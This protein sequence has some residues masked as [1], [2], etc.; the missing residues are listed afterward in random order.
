MDGPLHLKLLGS[1]TSDNG[2]SGT[3]KIVKVLPPLD[4]DVAGQ[5]GA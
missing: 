1:L 2:K 3:V 4:I 5:G